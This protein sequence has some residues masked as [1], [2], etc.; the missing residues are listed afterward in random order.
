MKLQFIALL[1][2]SLSLRA[3]PNTLTEAEKKEG[4]TLLFDGKSFEGWK[5]YK[6]AAFTGKGW[7]IE[8]GA[9]KNPKRGGRPTGGEGDIITTRKFTNYDFSFDWKIS[10]G[11]NSG[12]KYF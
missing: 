8:D 4:W 3:A 12:V 1:L 9:L 7:T 11:G 6:S 10:P 2:L 5:P